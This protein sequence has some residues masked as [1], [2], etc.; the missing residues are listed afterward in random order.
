M[1]CLDN[2]C[3]DGGKTGRESPTVGSPD[4]KVARWWHDRATTSQRH[5]L[6]VL[7]GG[8]TSRMTYRSDSLLPS[9]LTL[10]LGLSDHAVKLPNEHHEVFTKPE[11]KRYLRK[12]PSS[13]SNLNLCSVTDTDGQET[14]K[15]KDRS[16]FTSPKHTRR[17]CVC[18][19][20][21]LCDCLKGEHP[22]S[23][24]DYGLGSLP[25]NCGRLGKHQ[26]KWLCTAVGSPATTRPFQDVLHKTTPHK[27]SS[28]PF[29]KWM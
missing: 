11:K 24:S 1:I 3:C 20:V 9:P 2:V 8:L 4:E 22:P 26:R 17:I 15:K 12:S 25:R 19:C 28:F 10:T 21:C 16:N 14:K 23:V 13:E 6:R 29:Q 27:V 7:D 18:V 5:E